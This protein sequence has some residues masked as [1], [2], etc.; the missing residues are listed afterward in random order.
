[1]TDLT[2]LR[3]LQ[4]QASPGP[5][6]HHDL[7]VETENTE[8]R[9]AS[10]YDAELAALATHLLP[11]AEALERGQFCVRV[12]GDPDLPIGEDGREPGEWLQVAEDH[13]DD[14]LWDTDAVYEKA[15]ILNTPWEQP[16]EALKALQEA[17]DER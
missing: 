1:M 9:L 11:L 17:L 5:W 14:E 15:F 12:R 3:E 13:M 6:T 8:I 2:K 16:R 4:E 10:E 7:L